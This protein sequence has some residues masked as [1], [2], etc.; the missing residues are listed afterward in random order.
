MKTSPN[1]LYLFFFS[2]FL[3]ASS[4]TN[5]ASA[6]LRKRTGAQPTG[7]DTL[8]LNRLN[9]RHI[10]PFRGGR[11]AAVTGVEGNPDVYYFGGTGGGVW[12]TTDR[13]HSWKNI[14]DGYFGGSIGSVAVAPSD[15]NIVYAG[16]GEK[17]VRGNMSHGYGIWKST[18]AGEHWHYCG[19]KEGRYIPRIRV[20]P[21]DPQRVYA[22]VLGHV[23]GPNPERGVYR[24]TDGGE[25]W[26]KVLY[27]SEKAGAVDLV[28]DP[29]NPRILYA[30]LWEVSRTPYSLESG[31][32]GSGLWKSYDG[33]D[34][35]I[36]LSRKP[37]MPDG[38]LGITGVSVSPVNHRRVWAMVEAHE[39]GLFLSDDG[40]E[41]W[42]R[43]NDDRNLRQRAWYYT[44]VV[45]CPSGEDVVYVLNVGFHRSKDGGKSFERISTPHSDHHDLWIS[46]SDP[47]NMIVGNDGGAQVTFDGGRNWSTCYNQPTAQFYRVAT[48]NHF[49]FRIYAA[50]QDNSTVR[51]ASRS[52][53]YGITEDDW[54]ETAGGESGHIAP[55][56]EDPEI[57][58]GGSYGGYLERLDHRTGER[59]RVD[60]WPDNP[61]GS[62]AGDNR[63]RFQWNFPVFF[64]RHHPGRLYAAA[65]VLF[66]TENEGQSWEVISPDLTRND[67]STLGPSGGPITKDNT[68]VE[69]YGTIFAAAESVHEPGVIWTGSDDGLIWLT[70]NGGKNWENVTPPAAVLPEWTMIN[71]MEP[72]PFEKGGLYVAAT[73][74]KRN[75]YTPYLLKTTDYGKTW[76]RITHGIDPLHF[77]RVVRAD[78]DLRGLL[79]A[80]T[81]SGMYISFN[82]GNSWQPFQLNLPVVPVTDLAIKNRRLIVATQGRSLW[83]FDDLALLHQMKNEQVNSLFHLYEPA[84]AYRIEAGRGGRG[85]LGENPP[86]GPVIF[87]YLREAPDSS[88]PVRLDI[89]DATGRLVRRFTTEKIPVEQDVRLYTE[90]LEVSKGINRVEWDMRYPGARTFPG[91]IL[92]GGTTRGPLAL[93]GEY[94]ARLVTEKDS[95]ETVLRILPDPAVETTF[96]GLKEQF[97]FLMEIRDTLSEVHQTILDIRKLRGDLKELQ[98]R[99]PDEGSELKELIVHTLKEISEVEEALYQ[100]KNQSP[101]DP[102]NYP[103]R[104]NNKLAALAG[105]GSRGSYPPTRQDREVKAILEK[106]IREQ[107]NRF[108]RIR[109]SAVPMINKMAIE[110]QVPAVKL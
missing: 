56:P 54:E 12:K 61:M 46:S 25:T 27:V 76:T 102:L 17:T 92:W 26:E 100:T 38:P 24:S 36:N 110:L 82:D 71:S 37:G 33:G 105:A 94:T 34:T 40:G 5:D 32:P 45:A 28:I 98:K 83:V 57:V 65:N 67:P 81:E 47:E 79:Y 23:F 93:P 39:G 30:S 18:D 16:G 87:F 74:Y 44:R 4:G 109:T 21:A 85:I 101:Q 1:R 69:Y 103:I 86:S 91:M 88:N 52:R 106:A 77:T 68:S 64:S 58:Y 8:L 15:P 48:D 60:P 20:S 63:Y 42:E 95:G 53:G 22:A 107:L 89:Y 29:V 78:P 75:D 66:V 51:I 59:R 7:M 19:L 50:Q 73:A 97:T 104:L 84:P 55:D 2:V 99:I 80:G 72:H 13:G 90:K 43:V 11:S 31:G 108:S 62:G 49:P 70:R 10:G 35:W 6:Q 9:Y 14:S 3:I 96:D 41:T